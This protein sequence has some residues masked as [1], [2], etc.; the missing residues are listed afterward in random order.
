MKFLPL[1]LFAVCM[2]LPSGCVSFGVPKV[3]EALAHDPATIRLRF[4]TPYGVVEFD[5][6]SPQP[7]I[8]PHDLTGGGIHVGEAEV[9]EREGGRAGELVVPLRLKI[10]TQ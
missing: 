6:A 10:S 3:V 4:P 5:R 9:A 1:L 8:A 2:L 7:G